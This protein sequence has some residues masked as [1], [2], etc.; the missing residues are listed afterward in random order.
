MSCDLKAFQQKMA[1]CERVLKNNRIT[2]YKSNYVCIEELL[3]SFHEI[4]EFCSTPERNMSDPEV[5]KLKQL[6]GIISSRAGEIAYVD[7]FENLIASGST[8]EKCLKALL[9]KITQ[10]NSFRAFRLTDTRIGVCWQL[11]CE[12]SQPNFNAV[13]KSNCKSCYAVHKLAVASPNLAKTRLGYLY[14]HSLF[15]STFAPLELEVMTP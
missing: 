6:Q 12:E 3:L 11:D 8:V 7:L 13:Q 2:Y 1:R 15:Q 5:E 9:Q 14:T 4:I 10:D